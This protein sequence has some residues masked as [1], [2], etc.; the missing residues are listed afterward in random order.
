MDS[1]PT[2]PPSEGDPFLEPLHGW[3]TGRA[4]HSPAV[5]ASPTAVSMELTGGSQDGLYGRAEDMTGLSVLSGE[6]PAGSTGVQLPGNLP[7]YGSPGAMC[8]ERCNSSWDRLKGCKED[9]PV[10]SMLLGG[11]PA[12]FIGVRPPYSTLGKMAAA[13]SCLVTMSPRAARANYINTIHGSQGEQ[14]SHEAQGATK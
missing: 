10:L 13:S 3:G 8:M 7:A 2:A 9:M 5:M 1:S 12:N 4:S 11:V 6:I 14:T